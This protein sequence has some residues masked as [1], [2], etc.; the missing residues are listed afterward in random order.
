MARDGGHLGSAVGARCR[1]RVNEEMAAFRRARDD[2]DEMVVDTSFDEQGHKIDKDG[3]PIATP[4]AEKL[5]ALFRNRTWAV[6]LK[7]EKK[8]GNAYKLTGK[9][10]N[11]T[12]RLQLMGTGNM[13]VL[14]VWFAK[15]AQPMLFR[16]GGEFLAGKGAKK[17]IRVEEPGGAARDVEVAADEQPVVFMPSHLL[18]AGTEP[19]E[20]ERIEQVFDIRTVPIKEID[21]LVL[22]HMLALDSR[23]AAAPVAAAAVLPEGRKRTMPRAGRV[24]AAPGWYGFGW[25]GFGEHDAPHDGSEARRRVRWGRATGGCRASLR[26]RSD[27]LSHRREQEAIPPGKRAGAQSA[28]RY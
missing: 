10:S 16:I 3:K 21:A 8:E 14:K 20:I 26:R 18:P 11:L 25:Y 2:K 15:S 9:L 19:T 23:N 13:M 5:N 24:A 27:Y 28:R 7:V 12:D 4:E 6:D 22:G 17:T 1:S